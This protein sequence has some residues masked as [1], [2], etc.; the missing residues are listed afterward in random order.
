MNKKSNLSMLNH[1]RPAFLQSRGKKSGPDVFST[2]NPPQTR[3]KKE[4]FGSN[5]LNYSF[6]VNEEPFLPLTTEIR[7][8]QQETTNKFPTTSVCLVRQTE[9][10]FPLTT[11]CLRH[12]DSLSRSTSSKSS[13]SEGF[14]KVGSC[15]PTPNTSLLFVLR[16]NSEIRP[17]KQMILNFYNKKIKLGSLLISL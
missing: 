14:V 13:A 10:S 6:S 7:T 17:M 15:P 4:S 2:K 3:Q 12:M 8:S 9:I 11:R 16:S 5:V 1:L